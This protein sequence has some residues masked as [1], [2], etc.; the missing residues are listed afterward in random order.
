M[1]KYFFINLI[2]FVL[3]IF[4]QIILFNKI[5]FFGFLNPFPY[6]LFIILYPVKN[7]K[8]F[9]IIFSFLLGLII[10]M[11]LDSGGI[12]ALASLVLAYLR[13]NIFKFTF[14]IS[15]Q[16]NTIKINDNFTSDRISFL[17]LCIFLHHFVLYILQLFKVGNFFSLSLELILGTIFTF[18]LSILIIHI[19]KPNK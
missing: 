16:Y 8:N 14:G 6:I 2:R 9:L 18:I 10:D 5:N 12:H 7:N 3:L 4:F 17:I 19:F 15:Y 1:D 13:P 11:F